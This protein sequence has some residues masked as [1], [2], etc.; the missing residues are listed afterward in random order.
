MTRMMIGPLI[1][2]AAAALPLP[3]PSAPSHGP[4]FRPTATAHASARI[5]IISGVKF[6][7]DYSAAT[8]SGRR[9]AARLIDY[10]GQV[11]SAELLE[12]Q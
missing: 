12:F 9:R 1:F 11:R 2:L 8:T 10:D 5:R 6:G 4:V 7:Q 3:T